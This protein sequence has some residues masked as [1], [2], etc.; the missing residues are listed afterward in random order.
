[1]AKARV[2]DIGVYYEIH[3]EGEPLVMI[4]GGGAGVQSM[5]SPIRAFTPEYRVVVFDGR[6]TGQSDASDMP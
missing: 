2:G 3:G 5:L 6:G 4:S 1:M